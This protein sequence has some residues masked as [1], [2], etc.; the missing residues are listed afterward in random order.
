MDDFEV[1]GSDFERFRGEEW[2]F[3][4]PKVGVF[5]VWGPDFEGFRGEEWSFRVP[6]VRHI[7]LT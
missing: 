6:K 2:S 4:V 5:E 1:L 3:E 7:K